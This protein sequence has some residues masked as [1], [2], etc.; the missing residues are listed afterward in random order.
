MCRGASGIYKSGIFQLTQFGQEIDGW[1]PSIFATLD[2][3]KV[4]MSE[5]SRQAH[6]WIASLGVGDFR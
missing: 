5:K 2:C 6:A 3:L 1:R 4:Y